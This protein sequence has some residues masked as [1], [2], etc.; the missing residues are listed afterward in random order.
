NDQIATG[1]GGSFLGEALFRI[2]HL[3]REQ[4]GGSS[5]W[6]EVTAAAISPSSAF[7]RYAFGQRF[8]DL[9]DARDPAYYSRL[10][11]GT[12]GTT[13]NR[14][15]NSQ[16]LSRGELLVDYSMEYGLPETHGYVDYR[17]FV[18]LLFL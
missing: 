8:R 9:F 12:S 15:G 13:Q 1:I 10:Q 14:V 7:N 17:L 4:S 5:L 18:F 11:L 2:S 3:V 16:E 6:R